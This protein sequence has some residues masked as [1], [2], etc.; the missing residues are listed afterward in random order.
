M[1]FTASTLLLSA[2][3]QAVDRTVDIS[4][5]AKLV[6]ANLHK[7][8]F[9]KQTNEVRQSTK[10]KLQIV[11]SDHFQ[12]CPILHLFGLRFDHSN[13]AVVFTGIH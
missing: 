6:A 8:N 1:E 3:I 9:I 4:P 7:L 2:L 10:I 11:F 12:N 5:Y 13:R